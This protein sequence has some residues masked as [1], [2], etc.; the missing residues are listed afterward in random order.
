VVLS[1]KN[2]AEAQRD[3]E[4]ALQIARESGWRSA[5][6]FAL[7]VLATCQD[8]RGD[9]TTALESVN[10]GLE[11][12]KEIGHRQWMTYGHGVLGEIHLDLFALS[13]ARRSLEEALTLANESGSWHWIRTMAGFLASVCV[14]QNDLAAAQAAVDAAPA[15]DDPPQTLGQR[16]V[17]CAR[18]ELALARGEPQHAL[19][20]TDQLIA[21]AAHAKPDGS[22][23]LLVSMLRGQALTALGR[24]AEAEAA[25]V[26][27]RDIAATQGALPV[28]WR[29]HAALEK[30]YRAQGRGEPADAALA[31]ARAIVDDLANK[32]V[33]ETLRQN[34]VAGARAT[35]G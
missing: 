24:S 20:I 30:L 5:E 6:A 9:F 7:I 31:G 26:A 22:N 15:A 1:A 32:I 25:L 17:Y 11:I 3:V 4:A 23:I 28:L 13:S 18:V 33:D 35:L 21:S 16:L 19:E 8:S 34:F 12:A 27:A 10:R 14:A 2:I 29:I